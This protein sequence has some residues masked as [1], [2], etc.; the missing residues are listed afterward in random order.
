MLPPGRNVSIKSAINPA[1][2]IGAAVPRNR[3][4]HSSWQRGYGAR[5]M[6]VPCGA[7]HHPDGTVRVRDMRSG[8]CG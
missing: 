3:Q 8:G 6:E 7:G 1:G 4:D 5:V 2:G